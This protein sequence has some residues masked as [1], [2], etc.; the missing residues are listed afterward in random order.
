[1]KTSQIIFLLIFTMARTMA[2]QVVVDPEHLAVVF[3]NGAVRSA[4]ESTHEQYL[5]KINDNIDNLSANMDAVIVAQTLIYQGLSNVNSAL[6]NGMAV[7][8]LSVIIADIYRYTD[9]ALALAKDQPYLLLFAGN[10]AGEMRSRA[11]ALV[12]DVSSVILKDGGN[13]L[14]DFN[15]RDQLIRKVTQQLQILNGLAYGVWKS[16]FWA[17]QRGIIASAT[18]FAAYIGQDKMFIDRI[19]QQAKYLKP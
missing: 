8:N 2:Q 19:I 17:K 13:M 14:A 9:Q 6:E 3:Q 1:M 15:A 10:I 12:S 16:I 11:T 7:R 4:A 5:K 18:P